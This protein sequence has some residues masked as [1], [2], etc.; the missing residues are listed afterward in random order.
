MMI[1]QTAPQVV[2]NDVTFRIGTVTDSRLVFNVFERTLADLNRRMGSTE[3]TSA[4]DP[5]ALE[6]MWQERRSLYEHLARTADHFWIA[7]Y[8][9]SAVGFARSVLRDGMRQLTE[10]FVLPDAQSAGVGRELFSRAFPLDGATRRSILATT[11]VRAQAR[12]LKSGVYPR[13]LVFYFG[14][15]PEL[16]EV[17]ASLKVEPVSAMPS[18]LAQLANLDREILEFGRDVDHVWLLADRQGFLYHWDDRLVGYGYVGV[19]SGPFALSDSGCFP[20]VLAHAERDAAQHGRDHFGIEVPMVNQVVV[21]YAL[22][23]GFR[24]DSFVA[25]LMN[26]APFGRFENYIVTSP[27][28]FL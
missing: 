11:D 10:L 15:T 9:G 16:V 26:D 6:R 5:V 7:E 20:A 1:A 25:V 12:Y 28:F 13:F 21:D 22:A 2:R 18:T 8:E 4:S 3:R 19:R 27:P 23:R 14:R 17:P 24:M